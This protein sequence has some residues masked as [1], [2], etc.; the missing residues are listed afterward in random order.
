ML[1]LQIDSLSGQ[2]LAS[3]YGM[4]CSLDTANSFYLATDPNFVPDR[5]ITVG[6]SW[7]IPLEY[8]QKYWVKAVTP[9]TQV[10]AVLLPGKTPVVP[11]SNITVQ[12]A[13]GSTV[14]INGNV[15]VQNAPG[16]NLGVQA[17]ETVIGTISPGQTTANGLT[18]PSTCQAIRI[19]TGD[20]NAG[21]P[22]VIGATTGLRY[23]PY[24]TWLDIIGN[25]G[26]IF[27][28]EVDPSVDNKI[29]VTLSQAPSSKDV[30]VVATLATEQIT[31]K[32]IESLS[33]TGT[34]YYSLLAAGRFQQNTPAIDDIVP[35]RVG[36]DG[37][38][39]LTYAQNAV[40]SGGVNLAS[41]NTS[42]SFGPPAT[43]NQ[44]IIR[45]IAIEVEVHA[46]TAAGFLW[47]EDETLGYTVWQTYIENAPQHISAKAAI[48][49]G[50]WLLGGGASGST[51]AVVIGSTLNAGGYCNATAVW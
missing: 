11:P 23:G 44:I 29:N 49:E 22:T 10:S 50:G 34:N 45:S 16:T 8:G 42:H 28:T 37:G 14:D 27:S 5:T 43:S 36:G 48:P 38:L 35:L 40:G 9:N 15:D 7:S 33:V 30:Y 26:Y 31:A 13:S 18:L 21:S 24:Q 32:L 20:S 19:V 2:E 1:S 17:E 39:A 6:P 25:T 3:G 4:I 51:L 46:I 12:L 41:T 47:V